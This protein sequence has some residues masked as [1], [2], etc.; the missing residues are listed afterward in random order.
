MQIIKFFSC[1]FF[2][3]GLL[4]SSIGQSGA[5]QSQAPYFHINSDDG[6]E[7]FPLLSSS[8]KANI[9][10]SIVDVVVEQVYQNRG[11][12]PIEAIY[13]FPG[14]TRAAV[15]GMEAI[16]GK[17]TIKA[18]IQEKNKA[19]AIYTAA[20]Q[21]GKRAALLEQE[22]PNV[23][24]MSV[25]NILPGDEIKVRLKY[26]ELLIPENNIYQFYYPA[27][28][29]PRYTGE[30]NAG[31]EAFTNSPYL[32]AGESAPFDFD[33]N[34]ELRSS[35]NIQRITSPS[36]D[37]EVNYPRLNIATVNLGSGENNPA[38]RDYILEYQLAGDQIETGLMLYNHGDEKFFTLMMQPPAQIN[39]RIV[40]NRE[41]VFVVDVSGSMN[42]FPLEVSKNLLRDL[43]L[44]LNENDRFNLVFFA[45][46]SNV[47]RP[48][49]VAATN[50]NLEAALSFLDNQR[51][52][53]GTRLLN[54]L[55]TSMNLPACDSGEARSFVIISDGYISVEEAAFDYIRNNLN[56][57]NFFSFGI[58]SSPNVHLM[59]GIAHVGGG[60]ALIVQ[61]TNEGIQ[62]ADKFKQYIAQPILT[63]I[64]MK[65]EG[66]E[67]YDL[68]Q[69]TFPDLL[70]DRPLVVQGKWKNNPEGKICIEGY[71]GYGPYTKCFNLKDA[72]LSPSNSPIRYQWAREKIRLLDDYRKNGMGSTAQKETTALGLKYNLLT[73]Y[74]S[75]VAVQELQATAQAARKIKQPIP[76]PDRVSNL[77][78]GFEAKVSGISLPKAK[79]PKTEVKYQLTSMRFNGAK[80]KSPLAF[81][82]LWLDVFKQIKRLKALPK[83]LEIT[84]D[85]SGKITAI[86][87]DGILWTDYK[88]MMLLGKTYAASAQYGAG[89][90]QINFRQ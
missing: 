56:E 42:G 30:D 67:V 28:V 33:I 41:Y 79:R 65:T 64:K 5:D 58:G 53:G 70:A 74:T 35:I 26:T 80:I 78:V 18:I 48:S 8:A 69:N 86:H 83:T 17:D 37:I 75:F 76:L 72:T 62:K 4:P 77:A 10:G 63:K 81:E 82:A 38:G 3:L 7:N 51:G 25:G 19:K 59:E 87:L 32:R 40:P 88:A 20:V 60:E 24:R 43:L 57:A 85:A 68:S 34:V 71:T 66:F 46:A 1:V 31:S 45:G 55:Q 11:N 73:T 6:A 49:S 12:E 39:D 61:N 36:H 50:T 13:V 23:F 29:G 15:Y 89:V 44:D 21:S 90:L 52:G 9:A 47:W 27:T 16:I 2:C 14:S 54:A 84:I 22:R